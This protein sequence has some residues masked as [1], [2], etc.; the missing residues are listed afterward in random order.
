MRAMTKALVGVTA[1]VGIASGSLA[2]AATSAAAPAGQPRAGAVGL[3][4]APLAVNNL[5]LSTTQARYVQCW[6]QDY[7]GYKDALDGKLGTNSWKALQR[8]LKKHWGYGD[9][10]DGIV[11]PNTIKALQ[12]DLKKHHGYTG[13]IDGIAGAKTKAAFKDFAADSKPYC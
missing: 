6:I 3:Q 10:I 5:G 11:G 8:W 13:K 9:K 7:W 1:A 12:R 2:T 4:Q